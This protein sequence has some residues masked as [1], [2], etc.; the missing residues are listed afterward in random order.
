[1]LTLNATVKDEPVPAFAAEVIQAGIRQVWVGGLH[2][3]AVAAKQAGLL[4]EVLVG[5]DWREKTSAVLEYA[6]ERFDVWCASG[7]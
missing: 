7:F 6:S 2:A 5:K 4:A 3:L 1:V